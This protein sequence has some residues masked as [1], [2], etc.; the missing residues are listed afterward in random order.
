MSAYFGYYIRQIDSRWQ[1]EKALQSVSSGE[2]IDLDEA[3]AKTLKQYIEGFG[4]KN[5]GE[6]IISAE[7]R[8]VM[9]RQITALFGDFKE[10]QQK[11]QDKLGMVRSEEEAEAKIQELLGNGEI[12]IIRISAFDLQKLVLEAVSYGSL[13]YAE[14]GVMSSKYGLTPAARGGS[15]GFDGSSPSL[16]LR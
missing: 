5:M 13:L 16:P 3:T 2:P 6:I 8:A 1:L 11:L 4:P 10:M 9:S 14:E 15:D 12:D 7:A